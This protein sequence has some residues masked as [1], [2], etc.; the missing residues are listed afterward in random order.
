V[1]QGR[2]AIVTG[3]EQGIGWGIASRLDADGWRVV[4][5]GLSPGRTPGSGV[6]FRPL[7]VRDRELAQATIA[8]IADEYGRLDLLVNNAGIQ[9]HART[10]EMSWQDWTDVI[11]VNLNGVFNCLQAAGRIML[12][13]GEGSIVNIASIAA[14][15]GGAGRAPYCAAKSAVVGLTQVAGVEWAPRGVRVNAVGPGFVDTGVMHDA[16]AHSRLD[17]AEIVERIPAGR[18]GGPADIAAMVAF[19]ASAE[20]AYITGQV[21]FVDGGFLANYGIGLDGVTR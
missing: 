4:A 15:R 19:L 16:V 7:D 17:P 8:D 2:V 3:G 20:A 5:A 9:R 10:E 21:F 11:D 14:E 12:A 1:E 13:A 6:E 18:F